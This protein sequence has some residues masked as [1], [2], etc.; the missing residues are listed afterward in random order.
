MQVR[1]SNRRAVKPSCA[2][3]WLVL[4]ACLLAAFAPGCA[5]KRRLLGPGDTLP[6]GVAGTACK[7][8]TDCKGGLCVGVLHIQAVSDAVDAPDG[9]CTLSCEIDSQCGALGECSVPAGENQ[10][11]CLAGCNDELPCRSGYLCVGAS[12]PF[13]LNGTCQ[14]APETARL[15][16]GVVGQ[17]CEGNADC[18]EGRCAATTPLGTRLPGGYCSARCLDESDCGEGGGCLV[19]AGSS[20]AGHCYARCGS[21]ADCEREG[22]RCREIGPSFRACYPAPKALPDH[23]AGNAC[24]DDADCGGTENSCAFVL[25]FGSRATEDVEAPGGY[26]TQACSLDAECGAHAQCIAAGSR[27]GMCLGRC[28]VDADCRDG[29]RCISHGRDLIDEDRVCFPVL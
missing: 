20:N 11:E 15:E 12:R 26:C 9:Y 13:G 23:T 3:V 8:D 25:P 1:L 16:D 4:T 27:G 29:Y 22:Y 28:D 21:D 17:A 6:D 2:A 19:Y 7:R 14:P 5:R 10:G 18:G 24:G